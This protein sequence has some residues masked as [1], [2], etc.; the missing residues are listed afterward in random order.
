MTQTERAAAYLDAVPAPSEGHR[1][2]TLN[3]VAFELRKSFDLSQ[4]EFLDLLSGF[5]AAFIP[6]LPQREVVRTIESAWNGA[7]SKGVAGAKVTY[8]YRGTR[9]AKPTNGAGLKNKARF[10]FSPPPEP[11]EPRPSLLNG[12]V[13]YVPT[14]TDDLPEPMDDGARV[15]LER[16]FN[17]GEGIR[18]CHGG[19]K[20]DRSGDQ[21]IDDGPCFSREEWFRIF[22][23]VD[24]DPNGKFSNSDRTGIYVTV[25]PMRIG[26]NADA[27]VTAFRHC[28][29]EFDDIPI[30]AQW[31]LI[32]QSRIPC[33]AII[34]SGRKSLHAW[35]RV[36]AKDRR[37]YDERVKLLY[38]H[39]T[40]AGYKPDTQNKNPSRYSRLPNCVRFDSRQ[41]LLALRVGA[42]SFSEWQVEMEL[43]ACGDV[44]SVE[45]LRNF[46]PADDPNC[47]LG[48]R[49]LCR[50]GSALLIGQSGIGKSS[51]AVQMAATWAVGKPF[52]GVAPAGN[53]PLKSLIIQAE[54][55]EGDLA[56]M[57]QGVLAGLGIDDFTETDLDLVQKNLVFVSN[58]IHTGL[59][60]TEAAQR[61][62]DRHKPDIVWL[63]PLLSFIGDDVSRQDVCSRF[64][65]NWL[66]PISKA[67]GV[68]WICVHHTPK[69]SA[70]PK[71]RKGWSSADYSYAG[72]GSSELVNWARAVL[73]LRLVSEHH[74][75]LK[76]AKRGK[77]AAAT[78]YSG[79][80]QTTSLY[81]RHAT[82][83]I[84]WEQVEEP[85]DQDG[86]KSPQRELQDEQERIRKKS[87]AQWWAV[88]NLHEF[89]AGIPDEG[90][91]AK[92]FAERFAS[93]SEGK[94]PVTV[95]TARK[96]LVKALRKNKKITLKD[97]KLFR[98]ENS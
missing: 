60:F 8:T 20:P 58:T 95:E 51:L 90:E 6:P 11:R 18:I 17:E 37:E 61:L 25:N 12:N 45:R 5:A 48:N 67:T 62:I 74:F 30:T 97:G 19:M 42:A 75:E 41:E 13:K 50:G 33:S 81:L 88:Q 23:G 72:I 98:G 7:Q 28:L 78:A 2:S 92:A 82:S 56:E 47:V 44:F 87:P 85:D 64:L 65:R 32:Q 9:G 86:A 39:F 79:D 31:S 38:D 66:N 46:Q 26:G 69:P 76:L 21:P 49:Y 36:D 55:D 22:D 63:D 91:S 34:H 16:C 80:Y 15:L 73:V 3:Q 43:S 77:R 57:T 1:N 27:D 68:V 96:T 53:K 89:L 35:V 14:D 94:E 52:C 71:A 29:L 70:D 84:N 10:E 59:E 54:N 93:Y 4:S 24:G 83:G 40:A